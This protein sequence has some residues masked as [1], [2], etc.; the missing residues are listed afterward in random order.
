MLLIENSGKQTLM[1]HLLPDPQ[2]SILADS[3]GTLRRTTARE[4]R[5]DQEASQVSI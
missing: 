3:E 4:D 5:T 1:S 2:L